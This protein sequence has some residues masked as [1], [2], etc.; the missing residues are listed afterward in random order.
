MESEVLYS[1]YV[2]TVK[3][4]RKRY[5]GIT[6]RPVEARWD[7]GHGYDRQY[8]GKAIKKYGW[9]N[10]DKRVEYD[11]CLTLEKAKELEMYYIA[12][13]DSYN[14]KYGYNRT[15]GGD[16]VADNN[17]KIPIICLETLKTYESERD[18]C[19]ELKIHYSTL[20][21]CLTGRNYTAG[22]FHWD[23]YKEAK[24]MEYYKNLPFRIPPKPVHLKEIP[25][26]RK[27]VICR[28]TKRVFDSVTETARTF[29]V[30][31]GVITKVCKIPY[32]TCKGFHLAFYDSEK[33]LSDYD[34]IMSKPKKKFTEEQM[35]E[36]LK[37]KAV[38]CLEIE[39]IFI[40]TK[41]AEKYLKKIG[42]KGNVGSCCRQK[43]NMAGGYHWMFFDENKGFDYYR[44]VLKTKEDELTKN[45]PV[46]LLDNLKIY[47]SMIEAANDVGLQSST[48]IRGCCNGDYNTG[49][50]YHWSYYDKKKPLE[51]YKQMMDNW[52]DPVGQALKVICLET[53]EIYDSISDA[54]RATGISNK[55]H[56][57]DCCNGK[58]LTANNLHWAYYD[59]SKPINY[60]EKLPKE[61]YAK[62]GCMVVQI[63]TGRIFRTAK[64]AGIACGSVN[65]SHIL[66]CCKGKRNVAYGYHWRYVEE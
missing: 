12:L 4:N 40:S 3:A 53:L 20:A 18:A 2:L 27:S 31:E 60:Y 42:K 9:D 34:E 14:P 33:P 39:K 24:G 45:K 5:V 13:Y 56:I 51:Y 50:G 64:E 35:Q 10:I 49:G 28:E 52:V 41:E 8:F 25:K 23:Y 1:L 15:R 19:D 36:Y 54:N 6:F 43:T 46:I 61:V 7:N 44:E 59:E 30:G 47:N 66:D 16:T 32:M 26:K 21:G 11:H 58:R 57:T 37:G 62:E 29:G 17:R 55:G 22:G 48:S 38:I 65:G 63:E